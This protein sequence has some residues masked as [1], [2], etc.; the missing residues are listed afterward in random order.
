MPDFHSELH[1]TSD[2][3]DELGGNHVVAALT[4]SNAKAVSMWRTLGKFPWRTQMTITE[5]LRE[6]KKTAPNSLWG[7]TARQDSP[8]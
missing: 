8:A 7:M 3:I 2:V 6:R 1:T 4:G 5:A